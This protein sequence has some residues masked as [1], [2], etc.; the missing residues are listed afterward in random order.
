MSETRQ[1]TQED[2]DSLPT[3]E[4]VDAVAHFIEAI[5]ELKQSPF[6]IEE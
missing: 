6:F 1:I 2:A 3:Q 5:R 4:Q